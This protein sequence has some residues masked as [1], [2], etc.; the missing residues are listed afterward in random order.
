MGG[1]RLFT[2]ETKPMAYCILPLVNE[3]IFIVTFHHDFD[4]A[5]ELRRLAVDLRTYLDPLPGDALLIAEVQSL[6]MR[7]DDVSQKANLV[8]QRD[9]SLFYHPKV[10]GI[11]IVSSS[12]LIQFS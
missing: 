10:R 2:E 8:R 3:P 5:T 6:A 11:A 9:A 7:F 1:G 4:F 12:M